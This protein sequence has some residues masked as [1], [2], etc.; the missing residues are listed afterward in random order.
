MRLDYAEERR[1]KR[2]LARE[3]AYQVVEWHLSTPADKAAMMVG[4][5]GWGMHKR[6]PTPR[7]SSKPTDITMD[8]P[9]SVAA[10]GNQ[11]QETS[12]E[13]LEEMLPRRGKR[14]RG[15]PKRS[16][17]D[18]DDETGQA[19]D[20]AEEQAEGNVKT[21]HSSFTSAIKVD[22]PAGPEPRDP[23]SAIQ[24]AQN[25]PAD[26]DAEGEADAEGE[27]DDGEGSADIVDGVI[28]LEGESAVLSPR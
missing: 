13:V 17:I 9:D 15:K 5:R 22:E 27:I 3:F 28:G 10:D 21:E 20:R 14:G 16:D 25:Q 8:E 2:V 4:E 11:H 6:E 18:E 7:P 23:A 12:A 1:W 24:D 19:I 26:V